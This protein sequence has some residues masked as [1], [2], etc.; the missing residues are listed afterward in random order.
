MGLN[1]ISKVGVTYQIGAKKLLLNSQT[2]NTGYISQKESTFRIKKR[3]RISKTTIFSFKII[4]ID[5]SYTIRPRMPEFMLLY[6][7]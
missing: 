2:L 3:I 1:F 5:E 4:N 6:V 7:D